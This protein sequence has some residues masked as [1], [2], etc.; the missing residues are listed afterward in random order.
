VY[1][2]I[3]SYRD[4]NNFP[5]G[6]DLNGAAQALVRLQDTYQLDMSSLADGVVKP[7]SST[8]VRDVLSQEISHPG[9]IIYIDVYVD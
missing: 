1:S 6:D 5:M 2:W 9:I 3:G 4:G 7:E 8:A